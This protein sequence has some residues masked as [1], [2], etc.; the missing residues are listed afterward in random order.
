MPDFL[1][2]H[3]NN[4]TTQKTHCRV[5]ICARKRTI[6]P[7]SLKV[8]LDQADN[9]RV[10]AKNDRQP[11]EARVAQDFQSGSEARRSSVW[12]ALAVYQFERIVAEGGPQ[13]SSS[14]ICRRCSRRVDLRRDYFKDTKRRIPERLVVF[15]PRRQNVRDSNPKRKK[16]AQT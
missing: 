6:R 15:C 13:A 12:W 8:D 7:F 1:K 16:A 11:A 5:V 9:E 4:G 10:K 2:I 14:E 3:L